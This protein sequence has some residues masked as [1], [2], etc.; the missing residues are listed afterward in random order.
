MHYAVRLLTEVGLLCQ[1]R[2]GIRVQKQLYSCRA[3]SNYNEIGCYF[4]RHLLDDLECN[5]F[6]TI[7]LNT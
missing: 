7:T 4:K 1:K 5:L 3:F 2:Y 6:T